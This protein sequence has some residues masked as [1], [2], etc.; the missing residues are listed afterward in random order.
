M[1]ISIDN[2]HS[3]PHVELLC[4]EYELDSRRYS[5]G[6]SIVVFKSKQGIR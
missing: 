3:L 1:R 5:D 4:G 6:V 2:F